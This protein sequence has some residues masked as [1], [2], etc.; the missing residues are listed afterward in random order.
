MADPKVVPLPLSKADQKQIIDALEMLFTSQ[1]RA[2]R[3]AKSEAVV[4]VF[5][6]EAE[7]TRRLRDRVASLELPL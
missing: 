2:A 7:R 4:K 5:Q 6:D 3:A 1:M